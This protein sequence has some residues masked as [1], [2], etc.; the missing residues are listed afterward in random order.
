[1]QSQI[2]DL[3]TLS[4]RI[5]EK[6]AEGE[7]PVAAGFWREKLRALLVNAKELIATVRTH[8]RRMYWANFNT[9]LF[10]LN[11]LAELEYGLRPA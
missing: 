7:V 3:R 10:L 1:M 6:T 2:T 4:C 8:L 5:A 11:E 9:R